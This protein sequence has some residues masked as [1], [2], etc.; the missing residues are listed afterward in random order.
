MKL[1]YACTYKWKLMPEIKD[2]DIGG[3]SN[4]ESTIFE[5]GELGRKV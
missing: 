4:T 3:S 2:V 5:Y 1:V